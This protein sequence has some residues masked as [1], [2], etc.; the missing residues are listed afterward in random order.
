MNE[1]DPKHTT[2]N[3]VVGKEK[4]GIPKMHQL[5]IIVYTE[6]NEIPVVITFAKLQSKVPFEKVKVDE[7]IE[8]E[9]KPK[10]AEASELKQ[11]DIKVFYYVI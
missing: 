4:K 10:I 8:K 2:A 1:K 3:W 11:E 9:M 7:L 5:Q 6:E